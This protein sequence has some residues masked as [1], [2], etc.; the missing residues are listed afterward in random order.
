MTPRANVVFLPGAGGAGAFWR[1]VSERLP[2]PWS[3]TLLNWPGAGLEPRD[4]RVNGFDDLI[5]LVAGRIDGEADLVAQ[6][7]GGV[8]AIG[9]ALRHPE[10]VRR[11]VLTATSGGIDVRS[12]GAAEWRDDYRQEY[13]QA[14]EWI[15]RERVDYVA[16]I[17]GL[18]HPTLLIWG[19]RDPISP[20]S[21]GER[22]NDLLPDSRLHVLAGGTHS[23]ARD[24]AEDVSALIV[25]H[26]STPP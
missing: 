18:R 7:M 23:L 25:D 5:S 20:V 19:D 26:L 15:W 6:S 13:P 21:V 12:H 22:L 1:P 14:A 2:G 10:K 16:A 9:L 8:V 3:Q 4:P 11:L 24:R 17:P